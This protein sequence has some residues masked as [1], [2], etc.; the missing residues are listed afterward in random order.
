MKRKV[1][2]E[3]RSVEKSL[4]LQSRE[5]IEEVQERRLGRE[6]REVAVIRERRWWLEESN[7]R[8][9]GDLR[10]DWDIFWRWHP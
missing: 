9:D 8:G 6:S 10:T 4:W 5:W 7:C 1:T 2:Q 3:M